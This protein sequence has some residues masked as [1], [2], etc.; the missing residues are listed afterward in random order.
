MLARERP[1]NSGNEDGQTALHLVAMQDEY[2][3]QDVLEHG[4]NIDV[5]NL[6]DET[7]LM[8]AVNVENIETVTLLVKN[9]VEVNAVDN[10]Q[11]TCLHLAALKDKASSV[12]QL[13]LAH[14]VDTELMNRVVLTSLLVATFDGNDVAARQL[15]QHGAK[16]QAGKQSDFT[17]LH[18]AT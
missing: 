6:D 7:P 8:C 12:I 17:A 5:R 15:L 16:H 3:T 18:H 10:M 13:L 14:N 1:H 2:F 11:R 4:F 9:H